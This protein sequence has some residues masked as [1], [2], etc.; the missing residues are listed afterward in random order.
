MLA[1]FALW[2]DTHLFVGGDID[3]ILFFGGFWLLST[4][5]MVHIDALRRANADEAWRAFEDG[6]C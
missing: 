4:F 2:A 3:A 1:A 5:G 6:T